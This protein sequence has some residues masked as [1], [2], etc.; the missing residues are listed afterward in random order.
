MSSTRWYEQI[1]VSNKNVK[2]ILVVCSTATK[3]RFEI[4]KK[5]RKVFKDSNFFFLCEDYFDGDF[6]YIK[7]LVNNVI[8]KEF[9]LIISLGGGS[10]IDFTKTL[11]SFKYLKINKKKILEQ[12]I[13][14]IRKKRTNTFIAIPT[15]A[16]SG[17]ESTQF[18]VV[19]IKK[20]KFSIEN[21]I[22]LPDQYILDPQL[23]FTCKKSQKIASSLDALC[24]GIESH[25]SKLS[26]PE[27]RKLSAKSIELIWRNIKYAIIDNNFEKHKKIVL[28]SNLAGKA[29]NL[30]KTTANHALSYYIS[31]TYS[32]PHGLSVILTLPAFIDFYCTKKNKK[33]FETLKLLE[34]VLG[35]KK[36]NISTTI[37][38]M[39]CELG[40]KTSLLKYSITKD[41]VKR[42][43]NSVDPIRLKNNP[44]KLT[45]E[46]LIGILNNSF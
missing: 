40:V 38:E 33:V 12:N 23:S 14:K 24:Q 29:I 5:L 26:T 4:D 6:E 20:K 13:N 46:N 17:S 9:D 30:T 3:P 16:G 43:T 32:V 8:N 27:S 45:K 22:L 10:T 35:V 39:L 2:H 11:I 21:P 1:K 25:W 44:I 36:E 37:R 15:T 42:I 28:G 34:E 41:Q 31:K 7:K 18:A 19:Y